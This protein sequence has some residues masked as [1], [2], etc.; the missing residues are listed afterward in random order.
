MTTENH[1]FEKLRQ[2]LET[3]IR[4]FKSDVDLSK[5]LRGQ[6]D[7]YAFVELVERIEKTFA[8]E[9][10]YSDFSAGFLSSLERS[11]AILQQAQARSK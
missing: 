4:D 11:A 7:S 5:P 6:I 2:K 3:L 10:A 8:V 9:I 1:D